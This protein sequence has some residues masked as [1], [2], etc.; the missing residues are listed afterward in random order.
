MPPHGA[1]PRG[2]VNALPTVSP[3]ALAGG[4]MRVLRNRAVLARALSRAHANYFTMMILPVVVALWFEAG[5]VAWPVLLALAFLMYW[6]VFLAY[7]IL[8]VLLTKW[9]S[10][11]EPDFRARF[12]GA[13]IEDQAGMIGSR[14]FHT[15]GSSS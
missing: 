3:C 9:M 6:L 14:L 8:C 2:Q 1:L 7:F 12:E 10:L 5:R 11:R 4:E 15:T 13:S